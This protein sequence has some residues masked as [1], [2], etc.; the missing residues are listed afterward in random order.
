MFR[1]LDTENT[2]R[3]LHLFVRSI[4]YDFDIVL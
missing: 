1:L 3:K 4:D 2:Q